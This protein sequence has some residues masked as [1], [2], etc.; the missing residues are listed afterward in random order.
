MSWPSSSPYDINN[1]LLLRHGLNSGPIE[2]Q[3]Q[4]QQ[5]PQQQQLQQQVTA[6]TTPVPQQKDA[7]PPQRLFYDPDFRPYPLKPRK[8]KKTTTEQFRVLEDVFSRTPHITTAE[9]DALS[10]QLSMSGRQLQIWFQNRRAKEKTLLQK[11]LKDEGEGTTA[12]NNNNASDSTVAAFNSA[13]ASSVGLATSSS[14]LPISGSF[15]S[16]SPASTSS[17]SSPDF[18]TVQQTTCQ[19]AQQLQ[20]HQQQQHQHQ[21]QQSNRNGT[22]ATHRPGWQLDPD[23]RTFLPI[24]PALTTS[25]MASCVSFA[26]GLLDGQ[27]G[28]QLQ[29]QQQQQPQTVLTTGETHATPFQTN[30]TE[31]STSL[32]VGVP[33]V[34]STSPSSSVRPPVGLGAIATR[35][36]SAGS[37]EG[38]QDQYQYQL[39]SFESLLPLITKGSVSLRPAN[40]SNTNSNTNFN[41]GLPFVPTQ[42]TL[43]FGISSAS[44]SS[45]SSSSCT[46]PFS[47]ASTNNAVSNSLSSV[48][49]AFGGTSLINGNSNSSNGH[50]L[51]SMPNTMIASLSTSSSSPYSVLPNNSQRSNSLDGKFDTEGTLTNA[52]VVPSVSISRN[53]ANAS[54]NNK[55]QFCNASSLEDRLVSAAEFGCLEEFINL[56]QSTGISINCINSRGLTPLHAAVIGGHLDV[57]HWILSSPGVDLNVVD[58]ERHET[59]LQIAVLR[60]HRSIVRL[61]LDSG[62]SPSICDST[63]RTPLHRAAMFGC[64]L[65]S[66]DLIESGACVD[67]FDAEGQTPLHVASLFGFSDVVLLL[68]R[69]GAKVDTVDLRGNNAIF[70]A[71]KN[72]HGPVVSLLTKAGAA[73]SWDLHLKLL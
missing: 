11:K 64:I 41:G 65:I 51:V 20:H 25:S 15:S 22:S 60:G 67:A 35:S 24:A 32:S 5:V 17:S 27:L 28:S 48:H 47:M 33:F 52:N 21:Q 61:L 23:P 4:A 1:A 68:I 73:L 7:R 16:Q 44:S 49:S 29:M 39:P 34:S 53:T 58:F 31:V 54:S 3:L 50:G 9:R 10:S 42:H 37:F 55:Q 13:S 19:S 45:S 56:V 26:N 63:N 72:N 62:A 40:N 66:Q 36:S 18:S 57:L 59:P 69:Y 2:Q 71:L 38:V 70:Y 43:P 14:S 46:S 8:R 6:T 12:T 30:S